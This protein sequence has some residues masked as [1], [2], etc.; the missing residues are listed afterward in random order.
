ML[1]NRGL[2]LLASFI[3]FMIGFSSLVM[4]LSG[5]NWVFLKWLD[6]FGRTLGLVLRLFMIAGGV[7]GFVVANTNWERERQEN[8]MSGRPEDRS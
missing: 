2:I 3:F 5:I 4:M 8:V 6:A 7:V 1:K